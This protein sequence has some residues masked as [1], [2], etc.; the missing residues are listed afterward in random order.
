MEGRLQALERIV[1]TLLEADQMQGVDRP[2]LEVSK[3]LE[4][5]EQ[6]PDTMRHQHKGIKAIT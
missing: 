2:I 6:T 5:R 4:V 1:R 3:H